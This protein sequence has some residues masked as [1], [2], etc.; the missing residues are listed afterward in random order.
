MT[1]NQTLR[2]R[3]VAATTAAALSLGLAA[4]A[5]P[6]GPVTAGERPNRPTAPAVPSHNP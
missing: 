1:P 5:V 2:R 3:T 4:C 6:D